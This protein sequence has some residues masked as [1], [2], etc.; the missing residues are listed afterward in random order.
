MNKR[1][2]L[3]LMIL[4]VLTLNVPA[5]CTYLQT[6]YIANDSILTKQVGQ[7][8]TLLSADF[9][10]MS[11]DQTAD[12]DSVT[13]EWIKWK[14]MKNIYYVMQVVPI[15][16]AYGLSDNLSLR[17]TV[18]W[19]HHIMREFSGTYMMGYGIGDIK[20][21]ALYS[22]INESDKSPSFA[23]NTG[24]KTSSGRS[25]SQRDPNEMPVGTGNVDMSLSGIW[26]KTNGNMALKGLAGYVLRFPVIASGVLYKPADNIILSCAGELI[27]SEQLRYGA[28]LWARLIPGKDYMKQGD[29]GSMVDDTDVSLLSI[30]PYINYEYNKDVSL[31]GSLEVPLAGKASSSMADIYPERIF[32][33]V[34]MTVGVAWKI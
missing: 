22:I 20:F 11:A 31:K 13:D 26:E 2:S 6:A 17:V 29:N 15:R 28:E 1:S 27:A 18:P 3:I 25:F 8:K 19:V 7:G 34:N 5:Y 30:T 12:Y 24:L 21:E 10:Y 14:G 9:A 33:G 23:V 4:L 16:L 32:R